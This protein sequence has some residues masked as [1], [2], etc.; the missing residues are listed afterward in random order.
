M[1]NRIDEKLQA[2]LGA[3]Q[4]ARAPFITIGFPDVETSES[5]AQA[6]VESGAD[7]LE[8]GIPFSDPLADGPTVQMTSYRALQH[9]VNIDTALETV[10][11]LRG[12]G[13]QVPLIFMGYYNPY[14]HY[15]LERFAKNAAD[16]EIL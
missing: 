16:A 5:L 3:G 15:G 14:L 12:K 2:L 9:G 1:K 4:T 7:M 13:V 10:R 11:N 8:L 6:V